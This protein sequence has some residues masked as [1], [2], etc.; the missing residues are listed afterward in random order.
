MIRVRGTRCRFRILFYFFKFFS[1]SF[2]FSSETRKKRAAGLLRKPLLLISGRVNLKLS[3]L[4]RSPHPRT[5]IPRRIESHRPK[6]TSPAKRQGTRIV[7]FFSAFLSR[8]TNRISFRSP[9]SQ[10]TFNYTLLP[11]SIS[12]IHNGTPSCVV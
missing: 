6:K 3:L 4:P 10:F 12:C 7:F 1:F 11:G 8:P 2:C 9:N 5:G